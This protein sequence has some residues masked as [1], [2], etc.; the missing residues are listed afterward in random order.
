MGPFC[1]FLPA[2]L[3]LLLVLPASGRE[4]PTEGQR[5][6]PQISLSRAIA[7]VEKESDGRVVHI[8]LE[9]E[10]DRTVWDVD[11]LT[12]MGMFDYRLDAT[13]G[14]LVSVGRSGRSG[15]YTFITGFALQDLKALKIAPSEA[16]S[17][18]ETATASKAVS[19]AVHHIDG[20]VE[21]EVVA[22]DA[23]TRQRLRIDATSGRIVARW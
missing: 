1:R 18:A 16:A 7:I 22:R 13:S 19:L 2:L 4:Q 3:I 15:L 14:R 12:D 8:A 17:I 20:R 10:H 23:A 6:Q 5:V 21:Y 11:T 9:T